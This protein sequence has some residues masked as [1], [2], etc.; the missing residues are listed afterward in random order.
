MPMP[1]R[2]TL[3]SV[4][5]FLQMSAFGPKSYSC[6]RPP[7]AGTHPTGAFGEQVRSM[8]EEAHMPIAAVDGYA[9][10]SSSAARSSL[11]TDAA[12]LPPPTEPFFLPEAPFAAAAAAAGDVA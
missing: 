4:P 12:F 6:R 10:K 9:K 7:P 11:P 5:F 2:R 3:R 8:K 1:D